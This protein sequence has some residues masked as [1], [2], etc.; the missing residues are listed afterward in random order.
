MLL[1][2]LAWPRRRRA[3]LDRLRRL[4]PRARTAALWIALPIAVWFLV[5]PH[6]KDFFKFVENRSSGFPFWS[7]ETLA[8]YP[9]AFVA[10]FA[11]HPAI[12]V[13]ALLLAAAPFLYLRRLP[14]AHRALA[15]A[16]VVGAAALVLHPYKQPRFLFPLAPLVWLAA[17][18]T[19]ADALG[20]LGARARQA[21]RAV[22]IPSAITAA[23]AVGGLAAWLGWTAVAGGVDRERLAAR[24]ADQTVPAVVAPLLD[25]LADTAA[26]SAGNVF[27]GAWNDLSPALV[28][29]HCRLRHPGIPAARIPREADRLVPTASPHHLLDRAASPGNGIERLLVVGAL[30][31]GPRGAATF[32][33]ETAWLDP[34]REALT[35]DRRFTL[36]ANRPFPA[37]S[38][39]LRVYRL[40]PALGRAAAPH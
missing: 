3:L 18:A 7:L 22:R 39:R 35:T 20:A 17:A 8:L 11:P 26:A 24:H 19:L 4:E 31:D 29:W 32:R 10:E 15:L 6:V 37:A 34:V 25:A 12:G 5:P 1:R 28:E 40:A 16:L 27:V 14:P 33:T 21:G 30:G 36:E 2:H 13:A 38:Y 9:R 23:V